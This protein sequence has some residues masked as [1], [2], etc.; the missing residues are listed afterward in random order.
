MNYLA[1]S[2]NLDG[3]KADIVKKSLAADVNEELT[4]AQMLGKQIKELSGVTPGSKKFKA[5]QEELQPLEDTTDVVSIVY[6]V[7]QVEE[8]AIRQYKRIIKLCEAKDYVTQDLAVRLLAD[9]E[10]HKS[11]FESFLKE[12]RY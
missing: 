7:I 2:V 12:F 9:E 5:H 8:E 4:H 1:H 3:V 10:F 6:N 11:V